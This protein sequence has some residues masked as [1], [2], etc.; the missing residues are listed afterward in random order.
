MKHTFHLWMII[1]GIILFGTALAALCAGPFH[2]PAGDVLSIL[3]GKGSAIPNAET[4]IRM[5]RLPRIVLTVLAGAGLSAAGA[6]FQSLFANPL[7]T[8]DTLG[9]ANG[10][11]FGAAFGI[12]LGL[13]SFGV[14]LLA[15]GMGVLAV[16]LVLALTRAVHGVRNTSLIMVILAGMV[17]SSM[18]SALVSLVKYVADP[19]DVLPVITFWLM[20]SFSGT[21]VKSLTI[22]IPLIVTGLVILFLMRYRMDVLSLS[23]DEAKSLGINL[24][25]TRGLIIFAASAITAS[26]VALCGVIGWVGLL[27]PHIVR[28]L[29]GNS[30]AYVVPGSMLSGAIFMLLTDTAARCATAAEI[31]VSILTAVIGAPVFILLLRKTG[32]IQA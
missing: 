26:V 31:P 19:N 20:G 13:P 6:A 23:E 17:I 14:Q 10:A 2:V 29:L 21:T 7:A 30:N 25:L 28:M 18:F 3:S 4:T 1:M 24:P 16:L 27:I 15:L 5:V 12:L 11:S 32:G 9:T 8:P 22:G